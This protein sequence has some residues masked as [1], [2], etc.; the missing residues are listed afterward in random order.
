[1]N[2]QGNIIINMWIIKEGSGGKVQKHTGKGER[3]CCWIMARSRTPEI[4]GFFQAN[5]IGC[6]FDVLQVCKR[7]AV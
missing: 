2:A 4:I 1:M 3:L 6:E 7:L 5:F